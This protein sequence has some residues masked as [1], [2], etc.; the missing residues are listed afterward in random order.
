MYLKE[1]IR[2]LRKLK[3]L[4]QAD[5]G[6]HVDLKGETVSNYEREISKPDIDTIVKMSKFFGVSI[7]DLVNKDFSN[8]KNE[9]NR[10][11]EPF[12]PYG[13]SNCKNELEMC[14]LKLEHSQSKVELLQRH[15]EVLEKYIEK[16]ENK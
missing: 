3:G 11:E 13:K 8:Q 10:V 6:V 12:I 5:F 16:I 9:P 4:N 7:D 1:N 15:V 14:Q 2:F